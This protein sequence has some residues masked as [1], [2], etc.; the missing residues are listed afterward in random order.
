MEKEKPKKGFFEGLKSMIIEEEEI[1]VI[2]NKS[3]EETEEKTEKKSTSAFQP[4]QQQTA[5]GKIVGVYDSKFYEMLAAAVDRSNLEGK[6]YIEFKKAINNMKNLKM[7]EESKYQAAFASLQGSR[8]GMT[9]ED[10]INSISHY[11][12]VLN[13]ERTKF[14]TAIESKASVEIGQK[15]QLIETRQGEIDSM[16]E[17]IQK[18]MEL[19]DTKTDEINV[20]IKEVEESKY[21][22]ATNA[23]NF[24]VTSKMFE[25]NLLEEKKKIEQCL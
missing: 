24:S 15:E 1:E 25:E 21:S 20:T 7:A 12:E 22:L 14:E 5:P 19:I 8:N 23:A 3:E 11:V 6:D 4:P 13:Q 2:E 10:L 18:M 17:Q 16:N 9:K